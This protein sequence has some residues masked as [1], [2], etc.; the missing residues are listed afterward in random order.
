MLNIFSRT[1]NQEFVEIEFTR[2]K[3]GKKNKVKKDYV[4]AVYRKGSVKNGHMDE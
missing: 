1:K 2:N 4:G 3:L